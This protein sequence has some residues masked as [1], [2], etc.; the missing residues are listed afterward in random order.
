M[1]SKPRFVILRYSPIRTVFSLCG[2]DVGFA[3]LERM[4]EDSDD[5]VCVLFLPKDVKD[6][7]KI[8]TDDATRDISKDR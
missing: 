6:F 2:S 4:P 3:C 7:A 5:L 1:R 8:A